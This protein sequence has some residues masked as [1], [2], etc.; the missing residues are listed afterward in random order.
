MTRGRKKAIRLAFS[1]AVA[2]YDGEAQV[3]RHTAERLAGKISGLPLGPSPTVLEVGCG[4]GLFTAELA[5]R[6]AGA[7]LLISDLSPAMVERCRRRLGE[8]PGRFFLAMD[9]ETPASASNLDMIVSSLAVQW[10]LDLESGLGRLTAGLKPG[11]VLAFAT[12]GTDTFREW[13]KANDDL[14][15]SPGTHQYLR[16]DQLERLLAPI[17]PTRVDEERLQVSYPDGLAFL[18]S[19]KALGGHLPGPG[20]L[21]LSPGALRRVLGH[22]DRTAAG[23]DGVMLTHHLLYAVVFR[24]CESKN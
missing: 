19:L 12:F 7:R 9:G 8:K 15:H 6:F 17:G 16:R 23:Q 18:R 2:T 22:F 5:A 13:R 1:G 11:G 20:Y 3:H 14:G 10:F 21:P 24:N 4:T